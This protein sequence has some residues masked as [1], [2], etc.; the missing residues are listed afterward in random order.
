MKKMILTAV[1]L[2]IGAGMQII[3][4][5]AGAPPQLNLLLDQ[6][7]VE[8][9]YIPTGFS[10]YGSSWCNPMLK[11]NCQVRYYKPVDK[12]S[13]TFKE[14]QNKPYCHPCFVKL[15]A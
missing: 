3:S 11:D 10:A 14:Y 12:N 13:A 4:M 5:P 6:K 2:L 1:M 7:R 8:P 15:F 9:A